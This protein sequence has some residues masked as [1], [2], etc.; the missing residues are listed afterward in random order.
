MRV[1]VRHAR[2]RERESVSARAWARARARL[3]A[4]QLE[5]KV[6]RISEHL[7]VEMRLVLT[8]PAPKSEPSRTGGAAAVRVGRGL[9]AREGKGLVR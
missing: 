7:S 1:R 6:D 9:L 8:K 4:L 2:V 3:V 5:E